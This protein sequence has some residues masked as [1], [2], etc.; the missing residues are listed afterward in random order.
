EED[1]IQ[2]DRVGVGRELR[3]KLRPQRLELVV[4]VRADE[5][6]ED[7]L[8]PLKE[9]SG[10][11]E[12]HEYVVEG[13]SPGGTRDRRDLSTLLRHPALERRSEVARLDPIERREAERE[14]ALIE[15]WIGEIGCHG[16]YLGSLG[17]D[18]RLTT[19]PRVRS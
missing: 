10:P 12:G 19:L 11:L 1:R 16:A 15:E 8:D 4:G 13:G 6:E 5:V 2:Q 14:G 17:C 3:R 7:E 18:R 9:S